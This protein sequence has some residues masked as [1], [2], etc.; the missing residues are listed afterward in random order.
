MDGATVDEG[1]VRDD[2]AGLERSVLLDLDEDDVV[3]RDCDADV[4]LELGTGEL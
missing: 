4:G 2:D 3:R 1:A